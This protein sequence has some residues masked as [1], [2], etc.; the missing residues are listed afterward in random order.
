M[1]LYGFSWPFRV[2]CGLFIVFY[3]LSMV[4]YGLC[5]VFNGL[6][7]P[8]L[9]VID[10]NSETEGLKL[11]STISTYS[12]LDLRIVNLSTFWKIYTNF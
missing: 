11:R 7:S 2:L 3:G 6:A 9:V 1:V 12:D 5:M 10:P 4:F 8:F